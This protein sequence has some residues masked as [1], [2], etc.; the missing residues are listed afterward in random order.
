MNVEWASCPS[1][2]TLRL[3]TDG[4]RNTVSRWASYSGPMPSG[5]RKTAATLLVLSGRSGPEIRPS[6]SRIFGSLRLTIRTVS[7]KGT[8]SHDERSLLQMSTS[9]CPALLPGGPDSERQA[10]FHGPGSTY[11]VLA[12]EP[13]PRTQKAPKM[14]ICGWPAVAHR[15]RLRCQSH[16]SD[17]SIGG[18]SRG[19]CGGSPGKR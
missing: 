1:V 5:V 6:H 2:E 17:S 11:Q 8:A 4:F 12:T 16:P 18:E 7:P 9:S 13:I 15:R 3:R 14:T 19:R 10:L